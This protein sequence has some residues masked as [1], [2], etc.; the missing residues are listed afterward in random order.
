MIISNII[1]YSLYFYNIINVISIFLQIDYHD[2]SFFVIN[3]LISLII[4]RCKEY[5][6]VN[7][8][9][10]N[11]FILLA[12]SHTQQTLL[13]VFA[14]VNVTNVNY[15]LCFES[16]SSSAYSA[17]RPTPVSFFFSLSLQEI[18]Y[19]ILSNIY[20]EI[21]SSFNF[22]PRLDGVHESVYEET[23][24]ISLKNFF[25]FLCKYSKLSLTKKRDWA[26]KFLF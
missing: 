21:V 18:L 19:T 9:N 4:V 16:Q 12:K 3:E 23:S 2:V 10:N 7:I 14:C 6:Y 26:L 25:H 20:H 1:F 11:T 8:A 24:W 15:I 13:H 5:M 22:V 17:S